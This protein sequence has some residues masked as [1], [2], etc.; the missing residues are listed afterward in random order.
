MNTKAQGCRLLLYL[1]LVAAA[2]KSLLGRNLPSII[3][4]EGRKGKGYMAGIKVAGSD[5]NTNT[6]RESENY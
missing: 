4:S 1:K 2:Q 5:T 3:Y 6:H